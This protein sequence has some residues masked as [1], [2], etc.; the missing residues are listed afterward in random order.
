[1]EGRAH[2][3]ATRA[4]RLRLEALDVVHAGAATLPMAEGI[5][6]VALQRVTMDVRPLR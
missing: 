5:R 4:R 6:A 3:R 1:M 2:D